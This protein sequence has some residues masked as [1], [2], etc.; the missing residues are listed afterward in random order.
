[1]KN[2]REKILASAMT[3]WN[4]DYSAPLKAVAVE[5]DVSRMT[6]HRYFCGRESI[7]EAIFEMFFERFKSLL[8]HARQEDAQVHMVYRMEML[9]KNAQKLG[10]EYNFL[11]DIFEQKG[12]P[13]VLFKRFNDLEETFEHFCLLMHAKGLIKPNVHPKWAMAMFEGVMKAGFRAHQKM[14]INSP[15]LANLVWDAYSNAIFTQEALA[16]YRSKHP[17]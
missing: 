9:V 16:E 14:D 11:F 5:A 13:E 8:D 1:M 7:L 17:L 10:E 12:R 3:V 6:L 2:T 15:D 4:Q